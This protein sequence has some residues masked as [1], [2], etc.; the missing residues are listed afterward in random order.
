MVV[1]FGNLQ[2]FLIQCLGYID[3]TVNRHMQNTLKTDYLKAYILDGAC[4]ITKTPYYPSIHYK[5]HHT[6]TGDGHSGGG[7]GDV[8]RPVFVGE[9]TQ[10]K[11]SPLSFTT[12]Q[13][14]KLHT[15][16]CFILFSARFSRN[17]SFLYVILILVGLYRYCKVCRPCT[18]VFDHFKHQSDTI[19]R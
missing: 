10:Y 11:M 14:T 1:W 15:I 5:Q 7:Q 3:D 4:C 2:C 18:W 12:Y 17:M 13:A 16:D 8:Y 19:S 6:S 9:G